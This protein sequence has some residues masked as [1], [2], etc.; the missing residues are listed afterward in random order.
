MYSCF[1]QYTTVLYFEGHLSY[2]VKQ[3]HGDAMRYTCNFNSDCDI[4]IS[5]LYKLHDTFFHV[6][7]L[8]V[9]RRQKLLELR[10]MNF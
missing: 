2:I 10:V 7:K 1:I 4:V 5:N 9:K 6:F 8:E 3:A